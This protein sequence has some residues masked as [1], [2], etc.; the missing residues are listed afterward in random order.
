MSHRDVYTAF[1]LLHGEIYVTIQPSFIEN[2]G[3]TYD[4]KQKNDVHK[5]LTVA[6]SWKDC[7][8]DSTTNAV[9]HL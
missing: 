7:I 1:L 9:S 3:Q 8:Q 2:Q 6:S 5:N 4:S